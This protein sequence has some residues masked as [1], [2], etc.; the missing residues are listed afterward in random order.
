MDSPPDDARDPLGAIAPELGAGGFT[1]HDGTIEFY[2]RVRALLDADSRVLDYGAGRGSWVAEDHAPARRDLQLLRG[3]VARVVGADVDPV[4]QDN[5]ALDEAVVIT[6]GAPLP[7]DDASFD[8]V[9]ADWVFEH[10]D[11]PATACPELARVVRPGGWVCARTPNRRGLIAAGARLVPNRLHTRVLSRLQPDRQPED[12]FP[13]VYA[14]NTP[15]DLRRNF[16][17]FDHHTYGWRGDATYFGTSPAMVRVGRV[18]H[19]VSPPG[20]EPV[21]HVFLRRRPTGAS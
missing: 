10:L 8:L 7:F 9:V 4:V 17:D 5:P 1:R 19:H 21:W 2:T 20:L 3:D 15:A 14:L 12:V 11:D 16:P 6:P 13:T 18:L